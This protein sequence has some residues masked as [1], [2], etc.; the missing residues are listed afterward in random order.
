LRLATSGVVACHWPGSDCACG[1]GP[2]TQ[3]PIRADF[4]PLSNSLR[5]TLR[6][7]STF[8]DRTI[9]HSAESFIHSVLLMRFRP[10]T[11]HAIRLPATYDVP[12]Q[13]AGSFPAAVLAHSDSQSPISI[14]VSP[15]SNGNC[16]PDR[17]REVGDRQHDQYRPGAFR[18]CNAN[19]HRQQSLDR[20]PD[21]A[22]HRESIGICHE[23]DAGM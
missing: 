4:G 17:R 10:K 23:L 13:A 9:I 18:E 3:D 7:E 12:T 1:N 6:A 11:A 2:E 19:Q 14:A 21:E 5:R 15:R 8:G 16:V 22:A 20:L